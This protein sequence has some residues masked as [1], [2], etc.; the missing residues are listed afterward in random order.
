MYTTRGDQPV[1]VAANHGMADILKILLEKGCSFSRLES[2][3][4]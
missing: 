4:L 1:H 2:Y 3:Y